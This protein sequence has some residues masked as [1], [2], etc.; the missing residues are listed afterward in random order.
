[1]S[2]Q[3][4]IYCGILTP[5]RLPYAQALVPWRS[6]DLAGR[7]QQGAIADLRATTA[8]GSDVADLWQ[9]TTA[10]A[11]W[12]G[13]DGVNACRRDHKQRM[14]TFSI[15]LCKKLIWIESRLLFT[16]KQAQASGNN[17]G[18]QVH[19][20]K[21]NHCTHALHGDFTLFT[22]LRFSIFHFNCLI[23]FS[24][25]MYFFKKFWLLKSSK[26]FTAV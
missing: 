10:V 23:F 6:P 7:E 24:R 22:G 17:S 11:G 14:S 4:P 5:P 25:I 21:S 9:T 8:S 15:L 26:N 12:S 3:I 13:G 16:F 2:T 19:E 20:I 1:M 18:F